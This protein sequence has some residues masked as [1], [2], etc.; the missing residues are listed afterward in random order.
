MSE[1]PTNPKSSEPK[2]SSR[3]S[4][5]SSKK[6]NHSDYGYAGG[7]I[8]S[9]PIRKFRY[10]WRYWGVSK[11]IGRLID[12]TAAIARKT[13]RFDGK[14]YR[15][16]EADGQVIVR[17]WPNSRTLL[18]PLW[19]IIWTVQF[20]WRWLLTR[21]YVP[22]LLGVPAAAVLSIVFGAA[23]AGSRIGKGRETIHQKQMLGQALE[24][25]DFKLAS[26]C[27]AALLAAKPDSEEY[28]FTHAMITCDAGDEAAGL[29]MMTDLAID[30]R[31]AKAALWLADSV[32]DFN[33]F[34]AWN[35]T[36]KQTYLKWLSLGV[37][38]DPKNDP[39]RQRLG[40]ILRAAGDFRGAYRVLLPLADQDTTTNFVVAFLEQKIGLEQQAQTRGQALLKVYR[41]R[42]NVNPQDADARIQCASIFAMLG[43]ETEAVELLRRGIVLSTDVN[44]LQQLKTALVEAMVLQ[45]S[46]LQSEDSSPRG[47]LTRLNLLREAMG[48]DATNPALLEA[49]STACI[50]ASESKN[51]ELFILREA[52]VQ[53]VGSDTAHFIL[54][55]IALNQGDVD[56]ASQHL[57][58]AAKSNPNLPGLLNNLAYAMTQQESP[59][60]DRALRLADAA[61]RNLP[62]HAYLRETRGQI[63]LKLERYTDAIADLEFALSAIELRP[64]IREGLAVAYQAMGQSDIAKRQRE[65]LEAGR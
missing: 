4:K 39:P 15:Q 45:A 33:Q 24:R 46:A 44:Q 16:R 6:S 37:E 31:S 9:W 21:R 23:Y 29:A 32:G 7:T 53:G 54:G 13:V 26:L 10:V 25:G 36:Q 47:L 60:L 1:S 51:N 52:L 55:T 12:S 62:N 18:N 59:D 61:V 17:T 22:L 56:A 58:I 27:S 50:E 5:R 64:R 3:R 38:F 30:A 48:V 14:D 35:A 41:E 20:G 11:G 43:K 8:W 2:S 65:L 40:T 57:E 19:W 49:I 34:A 42:L 63:Y 28:R